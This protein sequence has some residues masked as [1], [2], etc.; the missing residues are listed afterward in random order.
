MTKIII[1]ERVQGA[2]DA[3]MNGG[4]EHAEWC[5]SGHE[6]EHLGTFDGSCWV[7]NAEEEIKFLQMFIEVYT[8]DLSS[9]EWWDYKQDCAAN[10]R[11]AATLLEEIIS[12]LW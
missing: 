12:T 10:V 5:L 9:D 11:A 7:V 3:I 8:K 1:N 4:Y 6:K 2:M